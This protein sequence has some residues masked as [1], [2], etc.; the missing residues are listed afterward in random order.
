[1]CCFSVLIIAS[2]AE[3]GGSLTETGGFS[4]RMLILKMT[5]GKMTAE[6]ILPISSFFLDAFRL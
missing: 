1:M 2:L 4:A 6:G 3:N 5:A